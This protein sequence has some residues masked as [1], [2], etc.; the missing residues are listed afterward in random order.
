MN[1]NNNNT[2][3]NYTSLGVGV[4]IH[5]DNMKESPCSNSSKY[6]AC[7]I[8]S[9]APTEGYSEDIE[10]LLMNAD[11]IGNALQDCSNVGMD[12]HS[13][14]HPETQKKALNSAVD[15]SGN[16]SSDSILKKVPS[17]PTKNQPIDSVDRNKTDTNRQNGNML[18]TKENSELQ[19]SLK[20]TKNVTKNSPQ[21][22]CQSQNLP[23]SRR[24]SKNNEDSM[25]GTKC[26]KKSTEGGQ[27]DKIR[28]IWENFSSNTGLVTDDAVK[29]TS[30]E[31]KT[32]V[33]VEKVS[34][35]AVSPNIPNS[36]A[37]VNHCLEPC[38][39][40]RSREYS[41]EFILAFQINYL[42]PRFFFNYY[43]C[44]LTEK[45]NCKYLF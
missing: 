9:P 40:S 30:A 16:V 39:D 25:T 4:A 10:D 14:D 41:S 44:N 42:A 36:E 18:N 34:E 26:L 27:H 37:D 13:T 5:S 17:S 29:L 20:H 45:S 11:G 8:D 21:K 28:N 2:C 7:V 22:K 31:L 3:T 19:K 35:S 33:D 24:Q 32:G 38:M 43:L 15:C 23:K 1:S 6:N 12:S